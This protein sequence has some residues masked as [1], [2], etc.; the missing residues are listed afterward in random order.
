MTGR[1]VRICV[2]L[3]VAETVPDAASC[4]KFLTTTPWLVCLGSRL[5]RSGNKCSNGASLLDDD[6]APAVALARLPC[7]AGVCVCS[8]YVRWRSALP[9]SCIKVVPQQAAGWHPDN[10]A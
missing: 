8:L 5:G 10:A 9:R 7:H 6:Y 4:V 3:L 2:V 1:H